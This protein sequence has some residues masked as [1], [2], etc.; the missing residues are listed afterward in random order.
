MKRQYLSLIASATLLLLLFQSV[1]SGRAA[2]GGQDRT[3]SPGSL[4]STCVACHSSAGSFT[5]P[6]LGITVKDINGNAVS[7]YT[8]GDTYTLEFQVTTNG[9]PS[10]YA[11]QAVVLDGSNSN[12]GD[13]TNVTT[14]NTQLATIANGREFI[15]HAGRSSSGFF[16]CSWTAP[17]AGTGT[18]SVYGV[19][20]AVNGGSTSG[21]NTSPTAQLVLSEDISTA[22]HSVLS[23]TQ[24]SI[25]PLPNNGTFR[26]VNNHIAGLSEIRLFSLQGQEFYS[27]TT[28]LDQN[29]THN[30]VLNDL[31]AGLYFVQVTKVGKTQSIPMLIQ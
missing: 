7:S 10:G 4:S 14:A 15:E 25:Y 9:S 31:S 5:N 2:S 22:T 18:V 6:L 24:Y 23:E 26:L 17:V 21:D 20:M 28:Y 12:I 8:A 11:M 3:G 16:S 13:L 30:I 27:Q 19:G 1:A 29:A